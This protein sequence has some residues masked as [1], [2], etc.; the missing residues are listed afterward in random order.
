M[1]PMAEPTRSGSV[2]SAST[3]MEP[4]AP[5]EPQAAND[6][7]QPQGAEQVHDGNSPTEP[8]PATGTGSR[9]L[10]LS[11]EPGLQPLAQHLE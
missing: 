10:K 1:P 4:V 5:P 9:S 7:P 8:L 2:S 3:D 6:Y 11:R